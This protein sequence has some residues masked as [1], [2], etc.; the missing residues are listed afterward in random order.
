MDFLAFF[1]SAAEKGEKGDRGPPG[2]A[3]I[4]GTASVDKLT[5]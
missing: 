4:P 5:R 3:E 2:I 1:L